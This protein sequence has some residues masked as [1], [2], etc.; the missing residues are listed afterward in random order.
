MSSLSL[1]TLTLA[2]GLVTGMGL[3]LAAAGL[4]VHWLPLG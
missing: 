3:G 1:I 4:I 2:A